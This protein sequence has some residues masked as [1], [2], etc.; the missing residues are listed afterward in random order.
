MYGN[1]HAYAT[2]VDC[3]QRCQSVGALLS[4]GGLSSRG[5]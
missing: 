2:C 4:G 5:A 3:V 1:A